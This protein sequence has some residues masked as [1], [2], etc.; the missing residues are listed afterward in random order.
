M[1]ALLEK[2]KNSELISEYGLGGVLAALAV[3]LKFILFYKLMAVEQFFAVTVSASII[4]VYLLFRAFRSKWISAFIYLIISVLMF[5]DS[6]YF[7]HF[8]RYLS[9]GMLGA[10]GFVG[11]IGESIRVILDFRH[12]FLF[13]D[14][15]LIFFILA[16]HSFEFRG[17]KRDKGELPAFARCF[18]SLAAAFAL[19]VT[20]I[21]NPFGSDAATALA[22]QELFSFHLTDIV[23]NSTSDNRGSLEAYSASYESEK[24]GPFFGVAAG[25]NLIII[26]LESFQNFVIGMKYNGQE[27]TP[28][29]NSLIAEDSIYFDN[30]FHQTGSGN[31]SDAEFALNDSIHGSLMS[32][33]YKLYENNYFRA[34][35]TLLSEQGYDTAVFHAYDDRNF[36]NREV[37]YPKQGFRRFYGAFVKSTEP[38]A[39]NSLRPGQVNGDYDYGDWVGWGLSDHDFYRQSAWYM[40]NELTAPFY[41]MLISL[42]NHHPFDVPAPQK[43]LK[44]LPED[45][46]TLVGNYLEGCAYTDYALGVFLDELKSRGMYNHSMLAIYGDHVGLTHTNDIDSSMERLLG[47]KY[48]VRDMMNIPLILNIPGSGVCFCTHRAGGQLDLMPTLAALLGLEELDTVYLGHNLIGNEAEKNGGFVA[49][50]TYMPRG[51]FITDEII[52]EMARDGV[53]SHSRVWN[54]WTGEQLD[55]EKYAALSER[56][57]AVMTTSDF[58]L[59]SDALRRIYEGGLSPEEAG[60]LTVHRDIF[61]RIYI[62]GYPDK[63]LMGTNSIAALDV[64]YEFSPYQVKCIALNA[65]CG[66]GGEPIFKSN[67]PKRYVNHPMTGER[68]STEAMTADE[69]AAW[70]EAHGAVNVVLNAE[71]GGGE[72]ML[73]YMAGINESLRERIVLEL[74]SYAE[75]SGHYDS[76]VNL[77]NAEKALAEEGREELLPA[78]GLVKRPWALMVS[79]K[80]EAKALYEELSGISLPEDTEGSVLSNIYFYNRE[81]YYELYEQPLNRTKGN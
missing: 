28:V 62:A 6:M 10:A 77:K 67:K 19:F 15:L 13:A 45:E 47:H 32:Y 49:I 39:F 64:S 75:Y 3:V 27:I 69:L 2:F 29:L 11:D 56:S 80:K 59:R 7:A 42:S 63:S 72:A 40:E 53:F 74:P 9:V 76:I 1:A 12:C 78:I 4:L 16:L 66:E 38:G 18:P 26:Q 52:F 36:W 8:N 33:T 71:K 57:T 22:N 14:A 54:M 51:S 58:I 68:Q 35:P 48:D 5:C 25:R 73:E 37:M 23:Q 30:F 21:G 79:N 17:V 46:G 34:F 41:A 20:V 61:D 60:S 31:T 81:G 24:E 55:P 65:E 70:L 44:L 50:Q 43:V